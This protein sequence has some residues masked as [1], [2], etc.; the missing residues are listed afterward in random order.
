M[1]SQVCFQ[2]AGAAEAFVAHLE[3]MKWK[4]QAQVLNRKKG[5]KV[6]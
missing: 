5:D 6:L 4:V 1:Q 2:V 3:E